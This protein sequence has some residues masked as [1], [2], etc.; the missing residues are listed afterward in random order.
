MEKAP[1]QPLSAA[2][3]RRFNEI[4][5]EYLLHH[6]ESHLEELFRI[7]DRNGNGVITTEELK[8]D[9]ETIEGHVVPDAFTHGTSEQRQRWFRIGFDKGQFEACNTFEARNL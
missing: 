2:E 1:L 3:I 9:L 6:N 5:G 8:L 7:F 4:M